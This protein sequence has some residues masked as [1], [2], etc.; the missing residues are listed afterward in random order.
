MADELYNE[1]VNRTNFIHYLLIALL[2][3]GQVVS[4]NE[5]SSQHS[6]SN[7]EHQA[8]HGPC[9]D[10]WAAELTF[11]THHDAHADPLGSVSNMGDNVGSNDDDAE[12]D[13]SIYHVLLK[14]SAGFWVVHSDFGHTQW[15]AAQPHYIAQIFPSSTLDK[16]PIRAPPA[17]A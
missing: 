11:V 8:L 13:C 5:H 12:V 7:S 9:S 4:N 1:G 2:L 6:L 17:N 16:Q 14:Q 3:Y 15:P 10:D